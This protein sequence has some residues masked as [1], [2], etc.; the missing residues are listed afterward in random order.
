MALDNRTPTQL[1][2]ISAQRITEGFPEQA[3]PSIFLESASYETFLAGR[4]FT[5]PQR[6]EFEKAY[7]A[8]YEKLREA[9]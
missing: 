7:R 4:S 2:E 1:G 9:V 6:Q 5:K 8:Q 3:D